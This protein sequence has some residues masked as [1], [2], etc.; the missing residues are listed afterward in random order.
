MGPGILFRTSAKF[1]CRDTMSRLDELTALTVAARKTMDDWQ[2]GQYRAASDR[3]QTRCLSSGRDWAYTRV[4][5]NFSLHFRRL[6]LCLL[7]FF[8]HADFVAWDTLAAMPKL[9]FCFYAFVCSVE[10]TGWI[11]RTQQSKSRKL[12]PPVLR[13]R[14][15]ILIN[16]LC[17]QHLTTQRQGWL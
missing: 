5:V 2:L 16:K 8:D 7:R 10:R 1:S 6:S 12:G 13:M 3:G 4:P 11:D 14:P 9:L 15:R 17:S